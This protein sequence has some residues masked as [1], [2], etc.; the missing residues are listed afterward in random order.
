MNTSR[1]LS[2]ALVFIV[3]LS[4]ANAMY[5]LIGFGFESNTGTYIYRGDIFGDFF[6]V[7]F[8]YPIGQELG[9]NSYAILPNVLKSYVDSNPYGGV[10]ALIDGNLT[11]FHVTPL[12]TTLLFGF[13]Q[14][15]NVVGI[16]ISFFILVVLC[17][18]FLVGVIK[19]TTNST[20][21]T[22]LLL[23]L[24]LVSYPFLFALQR[25]NLFSF[26]SCMA[27]VVAV[28]ALQKNRLIAAVG[29]FAIA[30]N[31]RPHLFVF[32][33]I[34]YFWPSRAWFRPIVPTMASIILFLVAILYVNDLYADYTV[35][36]FIQGLRIYNQKYVIEDGGFAYSMSLYSLVKYIYKLIH[37]EPP[38]R[39]VNL[40]ISIFVFFLIAWASV[41]HYKNRVS[42]IDYLFVLTAS[43]ALGTPVFADYHLLIFF[44]PIFYLVSNQYAIDQ[45]QAKNFEKSVLIL[46]AC[47]FMMSPMNYALSK[48]VYIVSFFKTMLALGTVLVV[49]HD[50]KGQKKLSET[51]YMAGIE[52][53]LT[54]LR[55]WLD[56][57]PE[58]RKTVKNDLKKSA[59]R[60]S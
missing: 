29:L 4:A 3:V 41:L 40:V 5:F 33:P 37:L 20:K 16:R 26:L 54:L 18:S 1:L 24:I 39:I 47:L 13:V 43:S 2:A 57:P 21:L 59:P 19:W 45:I 28:V 38:S 60:R 12:S 10:A 34:F 31:I 17:V 22:F 58:T 6:K 35:E 23:I 56:S 50:E 8:S 14:A 51:S 9:K 7:M 32:L 25:G 15:S 46:V 44:V 55:H 42:E 49:L 30:V 53:K 36:N 52:R 11:H 27:L 48:G